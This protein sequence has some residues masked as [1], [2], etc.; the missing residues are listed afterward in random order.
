MPAVW[1]AAFM[2][3]HWAAHSFIVLAYAGS[4]A[5]ERV[6]NNAADAIKRYVFMMASLRAQA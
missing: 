4:G 3:C 5:V 6:A 1:F 2:S